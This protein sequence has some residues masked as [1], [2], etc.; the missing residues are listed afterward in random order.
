MHLI[1]QE[2]LT[3]FE[4]LSIVS[5]HEFYFCE[6]KSFS[7]TGKPETKRRTVGQ[8]TMHFSGIIKSTES[9]H[10]NRPE[11]NRIQYTEREKKT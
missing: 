2:T 11:A 1:S 8:G 10:Y 7:S 3:F 4:E 9:Y 6:K 5:A